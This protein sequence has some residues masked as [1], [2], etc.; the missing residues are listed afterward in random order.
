[1]SMFRCLGP[2]FHK[3]SRPFWDSVNKQCY[4]KCTECGRV[5]Y[6][7]PQYGEDKYR[8]PPPRGEV[9]HDEL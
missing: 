6:D 4:S 2:W 5:T 3:W 7:I 1:M 9:T 8:Y